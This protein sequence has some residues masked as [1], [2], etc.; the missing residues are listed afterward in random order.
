MRLKEPDIVQ[1]VP[2]GYNLT[3]ENQEF[4]QLEP[5]P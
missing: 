2:S 3:Y 4:T 5:E 1:G